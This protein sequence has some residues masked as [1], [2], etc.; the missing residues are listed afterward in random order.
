VVLAGDQPA[1]TLPVTARIGSYRYAG[2]M[3]NGTARC[4]IPASRPHGSEKPVVIG[5]DIIAAAGR[6]ADY[7]LDKSHFL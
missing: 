4:G 3:V 7:G 6:V 2:V 1:D 5:C